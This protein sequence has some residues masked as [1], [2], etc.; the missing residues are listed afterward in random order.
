M[1]INRSQKI[2]RGVAGSNLILRI[3]PILR[4]VY[5]AMGLINKIPSLDL[6]QISHSCYTLMR[7]LAEI[8]FRNL[9]LKIHSLTVFC[10]ITI[11]I[12]NPLL[13]CVLN[14]PKSSHINEMA[15]CLHYNIPYIALL[16]TY[17]R[18]L[19]KKTYRE[20]PIRCLKTLILCCQSE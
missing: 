14:T 1:D 19:H 20:Q 2:L 10:L 15:L 9:I 12:K 13:H 17:I 4:W 3:L 7:D 5:G 6:S 8:Q 16:L 18:L 11:L